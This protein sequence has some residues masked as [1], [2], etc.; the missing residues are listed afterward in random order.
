MQIHVKIILCATVVLLVASCSASKKTT[1]AAITY[2]KD[3]KPIIDEQCGNKCHNA[4]RPADGIELT[5]YASVKMQ[6]V[7]GKLIPAIQHAEGSEPMPKKNPKL[8][9][10]S[11]QK[12]V[13]W[14]AA[15]AVE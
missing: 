13:D 5:T 4:E 10:V 3:V 15:G 11:I 8:D 9:D 1:T 7:E 14:V 12:I 2:T 6:S